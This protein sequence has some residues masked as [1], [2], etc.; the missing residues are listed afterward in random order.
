[1][2]DESYDGVDSAVQRKGIVSTFVTKDPYAGENKALEK[3][4]R[5]PE[6][7]AEW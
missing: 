5:Q 3:T 1:M 6:K 2:E 4:V 7:D